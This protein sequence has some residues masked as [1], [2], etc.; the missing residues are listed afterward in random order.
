ME[1]FE[2]GLEFAKFGVLLGKGVD[3][4]LELGVEL[5]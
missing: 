3:L 4:G 2:G 1:G 5:V